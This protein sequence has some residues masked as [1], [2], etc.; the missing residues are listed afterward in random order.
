MTCS[1]F[2]LCLF[3]TMEYISDQARFLPYPSPTH[4]SSAQT[5]LLCICPNFFLRKERRE[6]IKFVVP[7]KEMLLSFSIVRFLTNNDVTNR[8]LKNKLIYSI[9]QKGHKQRPNQVN[10]D[11]FTVFKT[12]L[13]M[14]Y[15]FCLDDHVYDLSDPNGAVRPEELECPTTNVITTRYRCK[16]RLILVFFSLKYPFKDFF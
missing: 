8:K 3:R 15:F 6:Q 1:G 16:V 11:Y 2:S 4:I 12:C 14:S 13:T 7:P 10:R 5:V 9:V